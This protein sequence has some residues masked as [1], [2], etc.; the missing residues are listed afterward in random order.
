MEQDML[1]RPIPYLGLYLD[2][3]LTTRGIGIEETAKQGV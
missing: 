3:T 1:S 2:L